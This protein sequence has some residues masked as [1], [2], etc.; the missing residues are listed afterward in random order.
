MWR[1]IVVSKI[2]NQAKCLE[3]C[4]VNEE[5]VKKVSILILV[6]KLKSEEQTSPDEQL[7][8]F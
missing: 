5:Q 6:G 8:F 7:S 4:G 1:D 3:L 2:T